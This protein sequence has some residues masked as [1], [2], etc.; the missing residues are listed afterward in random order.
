MGDQISLW[1]QLA[2]ISVQQDV[3]PESKSIVE[4]LVCCLADSNDL[5]TKLAS[6]NAIYN[7]IDTS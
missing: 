2:G 7:Y 5:K 1:C 4:K 6:L 3:S